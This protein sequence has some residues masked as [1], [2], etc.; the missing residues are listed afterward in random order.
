MSRPL[1]SPS[2]QI[3]ANPYEV[4]FCLMLYLTYPPTLHLV[5]AF[6]HGIAIDQM[7]TYLKLFNTVFGGKF[8][9]VMLERC[10]DYETSGPMGVP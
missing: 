7:D 1:E 10:D 3:D 5:P 8:G 4:C 2:L 9:C 6:D